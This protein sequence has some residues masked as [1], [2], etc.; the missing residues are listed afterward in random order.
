DF[1]RAEQ[2]CHRGKIV[3]QGRRALRLGGAGAC[4]EQGDVSAWGSGVRCPDVKELRTTEA[5]E[6]GA[7]ELARQ[8]VD[9]GKTVV[10]AEPDEVLRT[11]VV[12]A[13]AGRIEGAVVARIPTDPDQIERVYLDIGV[14][15]GARAAL[16]VDEALQRHPEG[17]SEVLEELLADRPLVVDG[18]D[19]VGDLG[20]GTDEG[21]RFA[22]RAQLEEL[23]ALL[24]KRATV[25]A[26]SGRP[27]RPFAGGAPPFTLDSSDPSDTWTL[28]GCQATTYQLWLSLRTLQ[29]RPVDEE[30]PEYLPE[31]D[32][33]RDQLKAELSS[34]EVQLLDVLCA[35]A[36]LL[37][38]TIVDALS[39]R[40]A[41]DCGAKLRLWHTD[42]RSVWTTRGW[43][44]WWRDTQ[45]LE[46]QRSCHRK[47]AVLFQDEANRGAPEEMGPSFLEALRHYTRSDD[48]EQAKRFA[49]YGVGTLVERA[50]Y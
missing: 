3:G 25:V 9:G 31:A 10:F 7:D 20:N 22:L 44:R 29:G 48:D 16:A 24:D 6:E 37:P 39:L 36:R 42:Q 27:K 26:I 50:R 23:S 41:V 14:Q 1:C 43:S 4:R 17:V 2:S 13:L 45:S 38:W 21:L 18:R 40:P 32:T 34:P 15:L 46:H 5:F 8:A 33:L 19:H 49:R 28:L 30:I 12:Q 35:H 47:L 11:S